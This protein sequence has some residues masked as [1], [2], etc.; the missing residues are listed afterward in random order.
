M[1]DLGNKSAE[2]L[3]GYVERIESLEVERGQ[4][5]ER[6]KSEYAEAAGVGFDKK[7]LRQLIKDRKADMQ[8]TAEFR[9]VV[10]TYRTAL[11][12]FADTELGE[13]A[14]AAA[15]STAKAQSRDKGGVADLEARRKAKDKLN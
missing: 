13:W 15:E 10:A 8:A 1:E 12:R 7:A 5:A 4:A 14:F 6:I 11:G 2:Q 9:A 3:A